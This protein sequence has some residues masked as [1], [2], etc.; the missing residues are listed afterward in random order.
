MHQPLTIREKVAFEMI[1]QAALRNRPCPSN[2][3]IEMAIGANSTS[4]AP[5]IVQSLEAKGLIRVTRFQR[6]RQ[7]TIVATG[8]TTAQPPSQRTKRPHVPRGAKQ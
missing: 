8:H 4:T 5:A 2:L 6:F 7:A 1:E 3:D